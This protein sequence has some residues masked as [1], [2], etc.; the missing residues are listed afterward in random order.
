M[1]DYQLFV[2]GAGPG[3][4]E[5]ALRAARLGLVRMLPI[6]QNTTTAAASSTASTAAAI[7]NLEGFLRTFGGLGGLAGRCGA[8]WLPQFWLPWPGPL[9][10]VQPRLVDWP[11]GVWPLQLPAVSWAGFSPPP[12]AIPSPAG[13]PLSR[14]PHS[15]QNRASSSL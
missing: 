15:S 12:W 3:G 4:Y 1:S 2:I 5:A 8:P 7:W 14:A 9:W 10:A 13:A 11:E 6:T